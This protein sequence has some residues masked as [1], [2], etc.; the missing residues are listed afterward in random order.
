MRIESEDGSFAVHLAPAGP[1]YDSRFFIFELRIGDVVLGDGAPAIEWTSVAALASLRLVDDPRVDPDSNTARDIFHLLTS[2]DEAELYD[3]TLTGFG[4]GFDA[5][6][7]RAYLWRD[8]A[9]FLFREH[10]S[11]QPIG[12]EKILMARIDAGELRAIA[13]AAKAAHEAY[14]S[15]Q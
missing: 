9:V 14:G 3:R 11:A 13:A 10:E 12:S 1:P 8:E 4:E 6:V 15:A 7:E 2:E 5:Y